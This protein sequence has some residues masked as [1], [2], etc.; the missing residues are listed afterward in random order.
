MQSFLN[1]SNRSI[2]SGGGADVAWW[3]WWVV[4]LSITTELK[5]G[6]EFPGGS[7]GVPLLCF[8]YEIDFCNG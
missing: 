4:M 6:V 5:N 3:F 1:R 8:P 2:C 7:G